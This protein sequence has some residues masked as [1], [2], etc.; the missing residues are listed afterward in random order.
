MAVL[1]G[2]AIA[3]AAGSSGVAAATA[4]TQGGATGPSAEFSR[5]L[6]GGN[7]VFI[8][9]PIAVNLKRFGYLQRE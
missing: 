2:V 6:A 7:G 4:T 9:S 3:A 1:L 5:A 8:G